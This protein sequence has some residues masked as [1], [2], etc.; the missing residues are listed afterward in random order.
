MT[1]CQRKLDASQLESAWMLTGMLNM[2]A[3][4]QVRVFINQIRREGLYQK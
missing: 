1:E 3:D 4:K 2:A